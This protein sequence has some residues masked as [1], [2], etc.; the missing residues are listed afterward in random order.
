M[1]VNE[2][3]PQPQRIGLATQPI[4]HTMSVDIETLRLVIIQS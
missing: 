2:T 3:T 1:L 4:L